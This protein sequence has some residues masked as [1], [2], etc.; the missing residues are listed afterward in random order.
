MVATKLAV[1]TKFDQLTGMYLSLQQS[2]GL[3][4]FLSSRDQQIK[5]LE[6]LQKDRHSSAR[7]DENCH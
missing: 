1:I 7:A 3:Q 6:E 4:R 5:Q 2:R